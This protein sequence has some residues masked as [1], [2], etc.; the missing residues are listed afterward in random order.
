MMQG[1][2]LDC[3]FAWTLPQLT[4]HCSASEGLSAAGLTAFVLSLLEVLNVP[5]AYLVWRLFLDKDSFFL[6]VILSNACQSLP[7]ARNGRLGFPGFRMQGS[8]PIDI[9]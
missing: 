3:L 5:F 9:V 4:S 6:T 2:Q 7:R 8:P 1:Q